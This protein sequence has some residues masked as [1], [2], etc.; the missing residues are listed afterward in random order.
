VT[1]RRA[2]IVLQIMINRFQLT[3]TVHCCGVFVVCWYARR[4][5]SEFVRLARSPAVRLAV[6][7]MSVGVFERRTSSA[8]SRLQSVR[9]FF[10]LHTLVPDRTGVLPLLRFQSVKPSSCSVAERFRWQYGRV[11]DWSLSQLAPDRPHLTWSIRTINAAVLKPPSVTLRCSTSFV[12]VLDLND[13]TDIQG[14]A[15]T[16]FL[17]IDRRLELFT[18]VRGYGLPYRRNYGMVLG[19][20]LLL[21]TRGT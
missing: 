5:S 21:H 9:L 11:E 16:K 14:R 19:L 15:R 12:T 7:H 3:Q 8:E 10:L 1:S 2:P 17:N 18:R 4:T 20:K 13:S 6:Q